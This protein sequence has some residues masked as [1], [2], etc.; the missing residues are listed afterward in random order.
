MKKQLN[1]NGNICI[2]K[3]NHI[4]STIFYIKALKNYFTKLNGYEFIDEEDI[5]DEN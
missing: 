5:V 3:K 4:C 1:I 2:K